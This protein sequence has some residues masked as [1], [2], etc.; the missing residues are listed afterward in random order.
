MTIDAVTD[1]EI[2][3]QYVVRVFVPDLRPG[4]IVVLGNLRNHKQHRVMAA[5]EKTGG[6][7]EFLPPYPQ[8]SPPSRKC[9]ASSKPSCA[10]WPPGAPS[11]PTPPPPL[12]SPSFSPP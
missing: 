8:T 1:G 9:E 2:F 4:D 10:S 7:V 5:I 6:Q 12:P 11:T 3:H